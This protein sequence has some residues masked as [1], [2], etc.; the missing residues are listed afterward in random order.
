MTSRH[1]GVAREIFTRAW[2]QG[3]F[4]GL[5]E[6][7]AGP[8]EF[9]IRGTSQEMDLDDLRDIVAR[10]REGFPDLRFE[11]EDIVSDGDRVAVRARLRGTNLGPWRNREP[12]GL[13]IDVEHMFFLRF[14][15]GHLTEV[16]ELLDQG[17]LRRQLEP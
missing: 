6:V 15:D 10:W 5:E 1:A 11:I 2:S 3:D 7:L 14:Q 16:F 13:S 17:A 12:T 8:F 9:H 4:S